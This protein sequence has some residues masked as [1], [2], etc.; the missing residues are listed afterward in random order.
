[1][2]FKGEKYLWQDTKRILGMPL[3]VTGY[4]VSEDRLFLRSGLLTIRDEEILLYRVR[5]ISLKRSAF[6]RM[7]GVGTITV[8][9]S[10]R[11]MPTLVI[12]NVKNPMQTKELIHSLVEEMKI[13]RRSMMGGAMM[14]EDFE[15]RT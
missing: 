8:S 1:M 10:D 13:R 6:Q 11:S 4:A 5:D 12:Q 7:L 3:S 2:K 15:E 14:P 9:S